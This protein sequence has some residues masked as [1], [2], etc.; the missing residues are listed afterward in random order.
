M[1]SD[2]RQHAIRERAYAKWQDAG[3]PSGD[4][5]NFWLEAE[6]EFLAKDPAQPS[7]GLEAGNKPVKASFPSIDPPPLKMIKA[8]G[9]SRKRVG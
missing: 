3:A 1:A 7:Q 2:S 6:Q 9:Q 8:T 4:G 5:I